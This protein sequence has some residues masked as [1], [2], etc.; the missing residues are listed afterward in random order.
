M[1]RNSKT[2]LDRFDALTDEMIDTS[3]VPPLTDK[4][5]ASAKWRMPSSRVKVVV[6][7]EPDVARWYK[8]QGERYQEFL[9]AALRT[10]AEEHKK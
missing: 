8:A 3:D 10:Y 7:L 9:A 2:N 6:E 4:F 5:F 1:S